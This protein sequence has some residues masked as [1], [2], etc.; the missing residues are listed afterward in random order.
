MA[1][2]DLT[3]NRPAAH[4]P[5]MLR[6]WATFGVLLIL[7]TSAGAALAHS[8]NVAFITPLSGPLAQDGK[9]ALNGFLLAT[10]EQ[11]GH[12]L[13]TSDGHLGGV[14]SNVLTIDAGKG[15]EAVQQRLGTLV[16][17]KELVFVT[18]ILDPELR[19]ALAAALA[20]TRVIVF[21]PTD[22]AALRSAAGA[23]G[24]LTTMDGRA[25]PEV[26]RKAYGYQPDEYAIRGYIAARLIADAV[27]AAGVSD[28]DAL[29]GAFDR[30]RARLD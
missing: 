22:S 17:G 9:R 24:R 5:V 10:R 2:A 15:I 28:P 7:A 20:R 13:E 11:D 4:W 16:R 30:A 3:A 21:D 23:S 25:F 8:F 27:R 29:R 6:S 12:A 26:F 18:G 19:A 1:T 14:D